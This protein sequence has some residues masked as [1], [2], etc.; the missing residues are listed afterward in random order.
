MGLL[1][2]AAAAS[3]PPDAGV[4]LSVDAGGPFDASVGEVRPASPTP[5]ATPAPRAAPVIAGATTPERDAAEAAQR[6]RDRWPLAYVDRPQTL[7]AGMG[8]FSALA[9]DYYDGPAGYVRL[10]LDISYEKA[11]TDWFEVWIGLPRA[12]CTGDGAGVCAST[13]QPELGV[14]AALLKDPHA[15]LAV[16]ASIFDIDYSATAWTRLKLVAAHRFSFEVEP[17]VVI[18]IRDVRTTAWWD[19]TVSQNGNQS[20][21]HLTLDANLQLTEQLLVW[22]DA[23]PYAPTANFGGSLDAAVEVIGGL[24]LSFTKAFQLGASCGSLN[25]LPARHWEYVPDVRLC[26]LTFVA[27]SFGQGPSG[28]VTVPVPQS[29]Y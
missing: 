11:L 29:L 15:H 25:V 9:R 23:I 3:E 24:T 5:P 4:S 28:V 12:Y 16:G 2:R 21:A 6:T 13:L 22:A 20:R 27:R 19:P 10:M 8:A 7:L 14:V 18:G 17:S 26:R 1:A